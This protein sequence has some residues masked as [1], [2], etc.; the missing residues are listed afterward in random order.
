MNDKTTFM[1]EIIQKLGAF[2]RQYFRTDIEFREKKWALDIVSFVDTECEKMFRDALTIAFPEDFILGEESF[3]ATHDYRQHKKLWII[4]PLDGTLMFK[5]GVPTYGPM[6]AYIEHGIIQCSAIFLPELGDLYYADNTGSYRNN[7]KIQVSKT[8]NVSSS[9]VYISNHVLKRI[10]E[11]HDKIFHFL[12]SVAKTLDMHSCAMSIPL[13]ASGSID[14]NIFYPKHGNMWDTIPGWFLVQ[15]AGG[16]VTNVWSDSW[17][18]FNPNV[19]F[20]NGLIHAD[21]QK[22]LD[23]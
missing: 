21:L 7:K 13:C 19:L 17:D 6:I 12:D 8:D 9:I 11:N 5:K 22:L 15:Q 16:K 20:S 3:D 23:T 14:A 4:D 18:I 1:L 10:L 2:Q